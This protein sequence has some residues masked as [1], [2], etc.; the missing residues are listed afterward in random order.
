MPTVDRPT[1]KDIGETEK[2]QIRI[3]LAKPFQQNVGAYMSAIEHFVA[4]Q[5]WPEDISGPAVYYLHLAFLHSQ[6]FVRATCVGDTVRPLTIFPFPPGEPATVV[7]WLLSEWWHSHGLREY[8]EE[9]T[10][11]SAVFHRFFA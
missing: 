10:T 8:V 1:A 4:E 3:Q 6:R 5:R 11:D 9:A 2:E 7:L